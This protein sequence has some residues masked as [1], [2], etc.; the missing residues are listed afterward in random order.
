[1]EIIII[2]EYLKTGTF[3]GIIDCRCSQHT[4]VQIQWSGG[5]T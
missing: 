4:P 5:K 3:L 2:G 1:M